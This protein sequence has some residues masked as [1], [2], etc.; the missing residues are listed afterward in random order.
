MRGGINEKM[1]EIG[2]RSVL[3]TR[4]KDVYVVI[5]GLLLWIPKY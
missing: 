3:R 5:L 4:I 1:I 2:L